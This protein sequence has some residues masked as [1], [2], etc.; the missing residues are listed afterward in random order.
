LS[1]HAH[2]KPASWR[3]IYQN[4]LKQQDAPFEAPPEFSIK[5]IT[6]N[7]SIANEN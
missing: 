7:K 6:Q 2:K 3:V 4:D 5:V 1:D